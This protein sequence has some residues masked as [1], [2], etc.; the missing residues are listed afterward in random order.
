MVVRLLKFNFEI[1][2][3]Y[4]TFGVS[5]YNVYNLGRSEQLYYVQLFDG[6]QVILRRRGGRTFLFDEELAIEGNVL[7]FV[8]FQ[9]WVGGWTFSIRES[10][11]RLVGKLEVSNDV[12]FNGCRIGR[13][14][15]DIALTKALVM[16]G[17]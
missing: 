7:D 9:S 14:K 4:A 1:K 5:S 3:I 8:V 17:R 15:A 16:Q 12:Y 11:D 2:A 13:R 6:R 10:N